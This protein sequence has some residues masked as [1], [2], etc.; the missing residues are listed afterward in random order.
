MEEKKNIE[1]MATF[2]SKKQNVKQDYDAVITEL[3]DKNMV[4]KSRY[5]INPEQ[6]YAID[7]F[8]MDGLARLMIAGEPQEMTIKKNAVYY[9]CTFLKSQSANKYISIH[10][11]KRMKNNGKEEEK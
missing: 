6:L 10:K 11:A 5:K 8:F 7:V 3:S 2:V 1:C 9:K 4:V